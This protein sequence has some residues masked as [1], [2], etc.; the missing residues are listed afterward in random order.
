MFYIIEVVINDPLTLLLNKLFGVYHYIGFYDDNNNNNNN[1]QLYYGHILIHVYY[2]NALNDLLINPFVERITFYDVTN[3]TTCQFDTF[4]KHCFD[5]QSTFDS[6]WLIENKRITSHDMIKNKYV[7]E[8]SKNIYPS[9][10]HPT[11]SD[12]D[13]LLK[14]QRNHVD[15]LIT[16]FV[17]L[18][19]N[20]INFRALVLQSDLQ[21]EPLP[22]VTAHPLMLFRKKLKCLLSNKNNMLCVNEWI[23]IY[24]HMIQ[25]YNKK[26]KLIKHQ[27]HTC[28]K[29]IILTYYNNDN[30]P[31]MIN[32]R[33]IP[34]YN[35]NL[36]VLSRAELID[37][38][39]YLDQVEP[40]LPAY[41][42]LQKQVIKMLNKK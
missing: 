4:V 29:N 13:H 32:N 20:N 3:I 16:S 6:L 22:N 34:I 35:A 19:Y 39:I 37:L 7:F 30:H 5:N 14:T 15:L 18:Y 42:I 23:D 28:S 9:A 17:N 8:L 2:L 11:Q 36:T 31:I 25:L 12:F 26:V 38:L 24:N 10:I 21:L 40:F 41:K 27:W 1:I 33:I